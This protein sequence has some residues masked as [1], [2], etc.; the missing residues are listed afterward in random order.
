[1][2]SFIGIREEWTRRL[3]RLSEMFSIDES[4]ECDCKCCADCGHCDCYE[5][6]CGKISSR[7]SSDGT[8]KSSGVAVKK[9]SEEKGGADHHAW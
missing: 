3:P 7:K 8:K 4:H 6:L 9:T 5:C 1:V 2:K